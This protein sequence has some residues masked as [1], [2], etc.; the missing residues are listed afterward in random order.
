MRFAGWSPSTTVLLG[1]LRFLHRLHAV[2]GQA[3]NV[4]IQLCVEEQ[5]PDPNWPAATAEASQRAWPFG[6]QPSGLQCLPEEPDGHLGKCDRDIQVWKLKEFNGV[7]IEPLRLSRYEYA[8]ASES[9]CKQHAYAMPLIEYWQWRPDDGGCYTNEAEKL[10]YGLVPKDFPYPLLSSDVSEAS[11]KKGVVGEF[12]QHYCPFDDTAVPVIPADQTHYTSADKVELADGEQLEIHG[13]LAATLQAWDVSLGDRVSRHQAIADVEFGNTLMRVFAPTDGWLVDIKVRAG[14]VFAMGDVIGTVDKTGDSTKTSATLFFRHFLVKLDDEIKEG[15]A[16]AVVEDGEGKSIHLKADASGRVKDVLPITDGE[17]VR[18]T[19]DVIK[20]QQPP[21]AASKSQPSTGHASAET[22]TAATSSAAQLAAAPSATTEAHH[23]AA[24]S[25]GDDTST[26]MRSGAS[27]ML[28]TS[29]EE[30]TTAAAPTSS[31]VG[32]MLAA[33]TSVDE[34]TTAA[35][36]TSTP[37][38]CPLL[39]SDME[40][41]VITPEEQLV[42]QKFQVAPRQCVEAGQVIAIGE[43]DGEE[44]S[45]SAGEKGCI[46]A[47]NNLTANSLISSDCDVASL[48]VE[49]PAGVEAVGFNE[50]VIFLEFLVKEGDFVEENATMAIFSPM[51]GS[52]AERHLRSLTSTGSL[53]APYSA[54]ILEEK[55]VPKGSTVI[56]GQPVVYI[57]HADSR[58]SFEARLLWYLLVLQLALCCC[59]CCLAFQRKEEAKPSYEPVLEGENTDSMSREHVLKIKF[60]DGAGQLHEKRFRYRPLGLEYTREAPIRVARFKE[61]SQAQ[62]Q[63]VQIGWKIVGINKRDVREDF[64]FSHVDQLILDGLDGLPPLPVALQFQC[65]DGVTRSLDIRRRVLGITWA[66]GRASGMV[67]GV[68]EFSQAETLGIQSGWQ[69]THIG[70]DPLTEDVDGETLRGL[71]SAR[72]E[73]LP[74]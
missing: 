6:A 2:H 26:V 35:A 72:L 62:R 71:L 36:P 27:S 69:L 14:A 57:E 49:L 45:I 32:S 9:A 39:K 11:G 41:V 28:S 4:P 10:E 48:R 55:E 15:Q 64:S 63:G 44:V 30:S 12:I 53:L 5:L 67:G 51:N 17:V 31:G 60:E 23:Q 7:I 24:K 59:I 42:F 65:P 70:E 21:G 54:L 20:L 1:V 43:A 37:V 33:S 38:A 58:K 73:H 46:E 66:G 13:S 29:V 19:E 25:P 50:P 52:S 3:P 74:G 61:Q 56:A 40:H 34:S 16:V 22:T 47:L 8:S 68:R 18:H